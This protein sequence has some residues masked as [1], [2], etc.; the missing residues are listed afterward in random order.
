MHVFSSS[1]TVTIYRNIVSDREKGNERR[2]NGQPQLQLLYLIQSNLLTTSFQ[3]LLLGAERIF[4]LSLP[5]LTS[6]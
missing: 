6:I 4:W 5:N 3:Q 1:K 2:I